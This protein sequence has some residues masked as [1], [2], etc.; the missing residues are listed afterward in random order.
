[1]GDPTLKLDPIQPPTN[2]I[3]ES[4]DNK[5]VLEWNA[6]PEENDG[7]CIYLIDENQE[8]FQ[9]INNVIVKETFFTDE[10]YLPSDLYEYAVRAVKLIE[11]QS[12]SYYTASPAAFAKINHINIVEENREGQLLTIAP[13]PCAGI[14]KIKV[15]NPG[16]VEIINIFGEKIFKFNIENYTQIDMSNLNKGIYF[17]KFELENGR[18][19]LRKLIKN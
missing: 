11:N 4:I 8:I 13:N 17:V 19:I 3:A 7:Y 1:M 18:I 12:G 10:N 6:S 2:L 14:L 16:N 9:K 5:V 15:N